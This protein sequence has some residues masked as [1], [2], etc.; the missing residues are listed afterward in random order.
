MDISVAMDPLKDV[1]GVYG[2]FI[3][4]NAGQLLHRDLS[5][6][7]NNA[8]LAR[9]GPRIARLWS[10]LP[11]DESPKSALLEFKAHKLYIHP[12]KHGNLC[13]LVAAKVHLLELKKA[14]E[15]AAQFLEKETT[16]PIESPTSTE[17]KPERTFVYR[18]QRYDT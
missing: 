13:V 10:N 2:C 8:S 11:D 15:C 9:A 4:D 6:I 12:L 17:T 14:A 7:V 5:A 18:G 3:V 16:N 1:E